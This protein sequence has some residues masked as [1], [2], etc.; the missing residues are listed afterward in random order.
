MTKKECVT[1]MHEN[2]DK[3][4][5]ELTLASVFGEFP[6]EIQE[7][8]YALWNKEFADFTNIDDLPPDL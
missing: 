6:R 5:V 7:K 8:Y 1:R 4:Q 2:A 3:V